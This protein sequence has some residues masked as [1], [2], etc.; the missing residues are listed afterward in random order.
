MP[1][2]LREL[3][4]ELDRLLQPRQ[5]H[6]YCPNGLQVEGRPQVRRLVTGVT[7]SQALVDA[8]IDWRADAI[9]VHHGYFWKGE[10]PVVTGMK[11]RRL[12]ALL[13]ADVSLLAYHLPLDAHPELGNNACLGRLLGI[14]E[15]EPLHPGG[16][17]VGSVATLDE[18]LSAGDFVDRLRELAGREPLHIGDREREVQRVAWCTGAAQGYIDAAL[19]VRADLYITGEASEQTVH[20]ARE[21]GIDFIAAGHHATERYGVQAVGESMAERFD[22]QHRFIDIENPV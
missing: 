5:F 8:A 18:P 22:L 9:L 16:E 14:E 7:A 3:Q 20:T 21:E 15:S 17:G 10:A 13:G 12:A 19:A 11:R 4:Q 6:D 1:V 2:S